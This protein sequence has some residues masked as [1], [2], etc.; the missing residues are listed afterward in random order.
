MPKNRAVERHFGPPPTE[1]VIREWRKQEDQLQKTDKTEQCFCGCAAKW[2]VRSG[3]ETVDHESQEHW[4]FSIYKND[5][6]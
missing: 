1:K 6:I 5:H 3:Y 2:P 4:L